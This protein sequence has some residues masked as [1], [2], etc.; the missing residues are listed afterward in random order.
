MSR[1]PLCC[2]KS[3]TFVL[4]LENQLA[5]QQSDMGVQLRKKENLMEEYQMKI[6]MLQQKFEEDIHKTMYVT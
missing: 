5:K 1:N 4:E 3:R 2:S 6:V